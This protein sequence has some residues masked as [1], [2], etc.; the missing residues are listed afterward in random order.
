MDK[1][2]YVSRAAWIYI[3]IVMFSIYPLHARILN[4][5]SEYTTIQAGINAAVD[6]DTVLV[7]PARYRENINFAD[8]NIIVASLFLQTRNELHIWQTIIDG[9]GAGSAVSF[10][11]TSICLIDRFSYHQ[12]LCPKRRRHLSLSFISES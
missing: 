7:Q 12:W 8:K 1:E 5:P 6:G 10:G 2:I 3:S 4:V 9:K 11:E